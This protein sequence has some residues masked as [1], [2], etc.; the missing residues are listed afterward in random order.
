[1]FAA[2]ENSWSSLFHVCWPGQGLGVFVFV[3]VSV[4]IESSLTFPLAAVSSRLIISKTTADNN[5]A[6]FPSL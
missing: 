3:F 4:A 1:M 2:A 5:N 6:L